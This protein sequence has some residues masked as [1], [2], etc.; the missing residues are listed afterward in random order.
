VLVAP[1]VLIFGV[2]TRSSDGWNRRPK[3]PPRVSRCRST[4]IRLPPAAICLVVVAAIGIVGYSLWTNQF[5]DLMIL[6]RP[7]AVVL[8]Q[9][10]LRS[11]ADRRAVLRP[12]VVRAQN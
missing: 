1:F 4:R 5:V 8:G 11:S 6:F 9:F 12:V 7:T 2:R 10:L 3:S